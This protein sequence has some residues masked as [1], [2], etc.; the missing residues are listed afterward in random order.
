[1]TYV[2]EDFLEISKALT[3]ENLNSFNRFC[4]HL[5]KMKK[6]AI[7]SDNKDDLLTRLKN[8]SKSYLSNTFFKSCNI[9]TKL[10]L[11]RYV[12]VLLDSDI[13]DME[14]ECT[15]L[16]IV[17]FDAN[18]DK[19]ETKP[20]KTSYTKSNVIILN[21]A[22]IL[23]CRYGDI[24]RLPGGFCNGVENH[25]ESAIRHTKEQ[26]GI[27]LLNSR[28]HIINSYESSCYNPSERYMI[29]NFMYAPTYKTFP[30]NGSCDKA[31]MVGFDKAMSMNIDEN[32]YKIVKTFIMK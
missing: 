31:E 12:S 3:T 14:E 22:K 28:L 21:G 32:D 5:I 9:D 13:T 29:I 16:S 7:E 8:V 20:Q 4:K 10:C 25:R 23:L 18:K 1:M 11:K 26:T 19:I 24:W 27:C 2:N 30:Y 17:P 6:K 15:E